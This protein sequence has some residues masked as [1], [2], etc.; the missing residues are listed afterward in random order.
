[1]PLLPPCPPRNNNFLPSGVH[2]APREVMNCSPETMC[3]WPDAS[4]FTQTCVRRSESAL[5]Y[6][7]HL[8]SGEYCG[9]PMLPPGLEGRMLVFRL[10]ERRVGEEGR[11][12]CVPVW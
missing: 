11:S 12:L 3:S 10:E 6:V 4:S 2:L 9:S 5:E 1:M 7:I 8:P